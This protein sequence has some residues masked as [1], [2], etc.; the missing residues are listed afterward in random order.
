MAP[1][2]TLTQAELVARREALL[3]R[4]GMTMEE[5]KALASTATLSGEE[6]EAAEELD[7]IAFLL[8]E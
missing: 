1:V 3:G 5:L 8:G 2:V 6:L 7:E 4:L